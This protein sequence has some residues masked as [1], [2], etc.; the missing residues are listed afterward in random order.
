MHGRYGLFDCFS[1]VHAVIS[2]TCVEFL[3]VRV[4]VQSPRYDDI[5]QGLF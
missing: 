2:D 4:L 5:E 3:Q 1:T